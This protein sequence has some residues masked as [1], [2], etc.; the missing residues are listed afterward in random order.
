M[1]STLCRT[2]LRHLCSNP[3][4][5]RIH[6]G[7]G[8]RGV[9]DR[10]VSH[11]DADRRVLHRGCRRHARHVS[12]VL[13][14]P[15]AADGDPGPGERHCPG[16]RYR[17]IRNGSD[18]HARC[19]STDRLVQRSGRGGVRLAAQRCHRAA[20]RQAPRATLSRKVPRAYGAGPTDSDE[21]SDARRHDRVDR[22]AREWRGIPDRGVDF[23]AWRG[24]PA[25]VH[26]YPARHRGAYRKGDDVGAQ[27]GAPTGHPGLGN[28]C[29][30]HRRRYPARRALQRR[31]GIDVRLPATGSGRDPARVVHPR[32]VPRR[33]R[34][35]RPALR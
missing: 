16:Q 25:T 9:V 2:A 22:L 6:R 27:R 28:G 34:R 5:D 31:G 33:A 15:P 17:R 8:P 23:P 18:H 4:A 14:D 12:A 35:A 32:P 3:D 30:H 13:A 26:A 1:A 21:C 7:P 20:R 11:R 10:L 24:R 29:D 19:G